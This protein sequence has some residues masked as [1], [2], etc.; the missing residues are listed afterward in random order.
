VKWGRSW[1][2]KWGYPELKKATN[3][4][5][6]YTEFIPLNVRII[7]NPYSQDSVR[8][9]WT[10]FV[11]PAGS[12]QFWY[13]IYMDGEPY[14]INIDSAQT[15]FDIVGLFNLETTIIDLVIQPV[16]NQI[17]TFDYSAIGDRIKIQFLESASPK[18]HIARYVFYKND[19]AGGPIDFT[20][21]IGEIRINNRLDVTNTDFVP[22]SQ[23]S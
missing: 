18:T 17:F 14:E 2:S 16:F 10:A 19:G 21:E 5:Y 1:S 4:L 15:Y 8:L 3:L 23:G 7:P 12:G 20:E 22:G 6:D 11:A 13:G 9:E